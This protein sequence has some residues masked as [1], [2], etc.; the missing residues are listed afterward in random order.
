MS[1]EMDS[2]CQ[3]LDQETLTGVM[4]EGDSP[5]DSS[6]ESKYIIDEVSYYNSSYSIYVYMYTSCVLSLTFFFLLQQVADRAALNVREA[7][8]AALLYA[9]LNPPRAPRLAEK[10]AAV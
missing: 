2:S 10:M 1:G 5:F 8:T 9:L 7:R 6:T 4:N 3:G